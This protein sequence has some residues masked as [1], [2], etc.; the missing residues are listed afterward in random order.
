MKPLQ[1]RLVLKMEKKKE[2]SKGGVFIPESVE[3]NNQEIGVVVKIGPDC[4][5]VK[6]GDRVILGV[7]SG[8]NITVNDEKLLVLKETDILAILEK[9]EN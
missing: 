7:Y 5:E 3:I 4:K 2:V 8:T 1:N 6:I 9:G